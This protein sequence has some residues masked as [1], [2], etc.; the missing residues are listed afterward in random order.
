MGDPTT[1]K[2]D[3]DAGQQT[4]RLIFDAAQKPAA[5]RRRCRATR[6]P[7][8]NARAAAAAAVAEARR[9]A[10]PQGGTLKVT[11]TNLRAGWLRKNGVPYSEGTMLTEYFDR[12]AAPN[13]DEWLVGHDD[14]RRP[15]ATSTRTFVTSSHFK[16]EPNGSKFAPDAVQGLGARRCP[17]AAGSRQERAHGGGQDQ[18]DS[19]L[20]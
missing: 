1:L 4:R 10:A 17:D 14:C 2:I 11:T 8:G 13:G 3:T 20:C 15:A 7:N 6:W 16:K 19:R 12:F 5:R 18:A 9:G